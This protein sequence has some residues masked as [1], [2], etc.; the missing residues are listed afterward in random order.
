MSRRHI[1]KQ[2][3]ELYMKY[4]GN[5]QYS[6]A[7]CAAKVGISTRSGYTLDKGKHATQKAK[8][9]R[10][11]K[12]R[13]S[14]IDKVWDSEL[15]PLLTSNPDLQ[16]MTLFIH[17]QREYRDEAGE[18]LYDKSL[19]RTLQ[20]RVAQWKATCGP[21]KEV[22]FAQTHRPG[23]QSLSDFTHMNTLEI[24][25]NHNSFKHLLYHF[26]LVYS[27]WSYVMVVQGGE[28]FQALSQGLQSALRML[29]GSTRAHRTD[30]LSAAYKN[31]SESEQEDM[32][33]RYQALCDNYGMTPTRNNKG[34]SHENGSVESS[35]GH[36]K[37]R[38]HQELLLRGHRDFPSVAD[39]EQW[40]Q[41]IVA[42]SNKRN[43]VNFAVEKNSL[44]PL[45]ENPSMDYELVSV[46]VSHLS[47]IVIRNMTYSV[48]SRLAGHTLTVH[49]YQEKLLL[50]LGNAHVGC[51]PRQYKSAQRSRYVIDYH[52]VIHALVKKTAAFRYCQY[53]DDLIP[54]GAYQAIWQYI[55]SHY[56]LSVAPKMFL[57][58][59]KLAADYDCE[60]TLG[61][62][63]VELIKKD[64]HPLPIE[65]IESLFNRSQPRLP[66][67]KTHQHPLKDY[68]QYIPHLT[69]P[70]QGE[71]CHVEL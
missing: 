56:S 52:H 19:I 22:C 47:M 37:N 6:Q 12:T 24:T 32:T 60:Q 62:H 29:G 48:P 30:S 58:L 25:I 42:H 14:G 63:V 5:E 3:M 57:R 55:D 68:D 17:L 51:L 70:S 71:I 44:R 66:K 8:R 27:K 39:Y 23:E 36:L 38:I 53:R 1:T 11:H 69:L 10:S 26:R 31:L 2:Q 16:P 49:V 65:Q 20:R 9:V 18:P 67:E 41:D 33:Q 50:Y 13:S 45:P 28:S 35:H 40:L 46:K 43:S 59:L 7:A 61:E 15:L 54:K 64:S 21:S 4:R 34:V